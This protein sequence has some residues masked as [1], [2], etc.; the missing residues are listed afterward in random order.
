M[1]SEVS[2]GQYVMLAIS[3][4]GS[5]M[6]PEVMA[7]AFEPFFTTKSEG[8]GTGLGLSMVYGFVKQSGGHIK[9][10][11]ELGSGTTF[12]I[13]LP[14]VHQ[15]E[16]VIPDVR[17]SPAIGGSE[18]ILVVEDDAAV[19]ATVVDMLA[20]LGYKVLKAKDGQSALT[21][22]QSGISID[23]LFTDVVMPGPVRS[24]DLAR[25]AKEL[26]PDIEVLFTSGYTQNAIVHGGKLDP[27]VELISKP[28]RREDLARKIRYMLSNRQH[29]KHADTAI[30]G[31][32]VADGAIE[33]PESRRI[34]V[35][36]DN[37]DSQ[38]IVCELLNLLGNVAQ[39]V[40]NAEDAI[41]ILSTDDFDILLTDIGLPGMSGMDLARKAKRDNPALIVIFAS[42][43]G[44]PDSHEFK[45]FSLPKPY[46]LRQ[47]QQV[48]AK[49]T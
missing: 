44:A 13:Y 46:D 30:T 11:S 29:V 17:T 19:Q 36:E 31:V 42:G 35:V 26:L 47:L 34:L 3:D 38:Q 6:S 18:T 7:R 43:Y 2:A 20:G 49:I 5:G 22:L 28:Y 10:Y 37:Q 23:M 41:K 45:S 25:Q 39:G 48:L 8:E 12:K 15:V 24:P 16:A 9:I 14:R 27:D 1:H 40:S 4:T 21:I 32:S 33:P